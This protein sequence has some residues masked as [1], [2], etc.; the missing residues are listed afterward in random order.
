M[1]VCLCVFSSIL[2]KV[3][4][5]KVGSLGIPC[6]LTQMELS[7]VGR[8]SHLDAG[9]GQFVAPSTGGGPGEQFAGGEAGVD[10]G[11]SWFFLEVAVGSIVDDFQVGVLSASCAVDGGAALESL[12]VCCIVEIAVSAGFAAGGGLVTETGEVV[13]V[14][15]GNVGAGCLGGGQLEGH[16]EKGNQS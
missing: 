6:A 8:R 11:F 13:D 4:E 16:A 2:R 14:V 5:G 15:C 3:A 12:G 10:D 9:D 7:S 1:D